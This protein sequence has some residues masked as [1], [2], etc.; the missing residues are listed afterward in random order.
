MK[1]QVIAAAAIR[2]SKIVGGLGTVEA[3]YVDIIVAAVVREAD[4][5]VIV[6]SHACHPACSAS[7]EAIGQINRCAIH[8]GKAIVLDEVFPAV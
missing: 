5:Q 7:I 1:H 4:N 6:E 8:P 2:L 3:R